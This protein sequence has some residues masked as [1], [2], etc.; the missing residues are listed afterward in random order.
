MKTPSDDDRSVAGPRKKRSGLVAVPLV[1][2]LL[3]LGLGPVALMWASLRYPRPGFVP[4]LLLGLLSDIFD[5]VIARKL[6]VDYSWLRRLDSIVDVIYYLCVLGAIWLV[7]AETIRKSWWPLTL[8]LG[9]EIAC[10]AV[11]FARFRSFPATHCNTAK[12]YGLGL[13]CAFAG[14]LGFGLGAWVFAALTVIGL[15]ANAE[16]LLVLFLSKSAPVDVRSVFDL[17]RNTVGR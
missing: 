17:K 5:G 9:S 4:L 11:G 14:V 13:F 10:I 12:L 16:V 6:K 7:A 1:L 3:R 8:L 15:V 2:T